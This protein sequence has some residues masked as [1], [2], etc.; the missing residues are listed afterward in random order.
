MC[1][2][3][4]KHFCTSY[5]FL[6]CFTTTHEIYTR[7]L[8]WPLLLR[9]GQSGRLS[10][11]PVIK[12][13]TNP[14]LCCGGDVSTWRDRCGGQACSQTIVPARRGNICSVC[15][16]SPQILAST[17]Q[18]ESI[19]LLQVFL[20][21][22]PVPVKTASVAYYP[23]WPCSRCAAPPPCRSSSSSP[24]SPSPLTSTGCATPTGRPPTCSHPPTQTSSLLGYSKIKLN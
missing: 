12:E 20:Y 1:G 10:N 17:V 21:L 23:W 13:L 4:E 11:C 2:R 15:G 16:G 7:L 18:A 5:C 6:Y 14:G 22:L 3:F 9:I 24:A 19:R 8:M